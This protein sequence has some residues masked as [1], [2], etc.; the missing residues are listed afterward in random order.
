[1]LP[2]RARDLK[3]ADLA[4]LI[5]KLDFGPT[6][7]DEAATELAANSI[8]LDL[9]RRRFIYKAGDPADSLYAIVQGRI[10]LCRIDPVSKREAVIDILSEGSLFGESALYS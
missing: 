9:R 7:S 8:V 4:A 3:T 5:R 6:L 1:M 10:K 2:K